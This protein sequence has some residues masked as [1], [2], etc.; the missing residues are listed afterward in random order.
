MIDWKRKG[1]LFNRWIKRQD[2]DIFTEIKKHL[3]FTIKIHSIQSSYNILKLNELFTIELRHYYKMK[4]EKIDSITN[5]YYHDLEI[6][7]QC[8]PAQLNKIIEE[9]YL[10]NPSREGKMIKKESK[11][12]RINKKNTL[13]S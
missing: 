9:V 8:E 5:P 13:R 12:I 7:R 3:T 11:L 4:N 2:T 1:R 6:A 10:D